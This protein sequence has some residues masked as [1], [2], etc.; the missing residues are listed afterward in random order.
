MTFIGNLMKIFYYNVLTF[1]LTVPLRLKGVAFGKKARIGPGYDI[2]GLCQK[3]VSLSEGVIIGRRAWLQT[4]NRE[5]GQIEIGARTSIGRDAVISSSSLIKIG[6]ECILSYR[7]SVFDHDHAFILG[8]PP[9]KTQVDR[10]AP[11][12]IGDRTFIGANS[13]IL[14]GVTIGDDCIIGA[15]SIVTTDIPSQSI[16]AGNPAVVIRKRNK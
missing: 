7:V 1:A 16:A 8:G 12:F 15:G 14:S 13:F 6:M 11:V 5:Q 4:F 9:S 2:F 10:G 3:N